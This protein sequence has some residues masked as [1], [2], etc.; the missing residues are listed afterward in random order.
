MPHLQAGRWLSA[1]APRSHEG[2]ILEAIA[3]PGPEEACGAPDFINV[4]DDDMIFFVFS[5]TLGVTWVIPTTGMH[6]ESV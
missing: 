1:K 6:S 4:N 5:G 2:K 3:S